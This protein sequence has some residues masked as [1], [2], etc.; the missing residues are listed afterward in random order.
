VRVRS[1]QLLKLL[2]RGD[3]R[4]VVD[5]ESRTGDRQPSATTPHDVALRRLLRKR[6]RCV[7]PPG[8][9]EQS[10][11][12]HGWSEQVRTV[13]QR[14]RRWQL[15][16]RAERSVSGMADDHHLRSRRI[17]RRQPELVRG[18]RRELLGR[19]RGRSLERP[20]EIRVRV[21]ARLRKRWRTCENR[22]ET[23]DEPSQRGLNHSPTLHA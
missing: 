4:I 11:R 21:H 14:R 9:K 12:E 22:D 3:P 10:T 7:M 16:E 6:R 2:R 15:I 13:G 18:K 20:T 23:D 8:P 19:D 5:S 1:T 17:G